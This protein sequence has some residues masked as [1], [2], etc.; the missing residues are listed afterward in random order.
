M[1]TSDAAIKPIIDNWT[2]ETPEAGSS[3][4]EVTDDSGANCNGVKTIAGHFP[5]KETRN[6][7]HRTIR[8]VEIL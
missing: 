1:F 2:D 7:Q 6:H 8:L 3:M 4:H 5:K